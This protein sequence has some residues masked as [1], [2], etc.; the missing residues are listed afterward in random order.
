[1]STKK[2]G[3]GSKDM[4]ERQKDQRISWKRPGEKSAKTGGGADECVWKERVRSPFVHCLVVSFATIKQTAIV[5]KRKC[6]HN[7]LFALKVNNIY[8]VT[9]R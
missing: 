8:M 1:M 3:K 4:R 9:I 2:D 7:T 6:T 5:Q